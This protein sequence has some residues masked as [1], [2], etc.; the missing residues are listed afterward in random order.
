MGLDGLNLNSEILSLQEKKEKLK[1]L[2]DN[3]KSN[4]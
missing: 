2:V 3:A 1:L 4:E